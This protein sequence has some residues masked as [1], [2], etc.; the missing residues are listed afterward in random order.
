MGKIYVIIGKSASGKDHIYQSILKDSGL[1]L[2]K[3]VSYTTRPKRENE[4]NG[5]EYFFSNE[6]QLAEFRKKGK[7][8]EERVYETIYGPW[9]Y[10]LVDD[11]QI[12]ADK[13]DYLTIGTIESF[14]SM[15]KYFKDIVCP[16][17]IEVDDGIRLIRAVKREQEQ[18]KPGYNE[19][20]RRFLADSEDFSEEKL[21]EAGIIKRFS[22]NGRI[23][24]CIDEIKNYIKKFLI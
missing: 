22:N 14:M 2:K 17:Y 7:I 15:K 12:Q 8:I 24:D 19:V 13:Y 1:D 3:I 10:F 18:P 6:D 4:E 21:K 20:C 11:G 5:K 9:Y 23:E 16:I